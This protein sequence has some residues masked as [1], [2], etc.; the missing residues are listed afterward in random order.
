MHRYL[1]PLIRQDLKEKMV[2]MG[3]PRQVGKTTLAFQLLGNTGE[4]HPGYL[5]WDA[6][7]VKRALL[8]G[9]LPAQ[10]PLLIFD[11][12]HK[13]KHWRNLIKGIY[14]Q[15]KSQRQI[16]VTGSARL[17]FYRRGGD[18][19]QGRYHYYRLHPLTL[20]EISKQPHS[21]DL[22][23]LLKFGG[24]PE[25]FLK[26]EARH[27]K[28][29][30]N[31]RLTRVVQED[32]V[33]LEHVKE[34]SQI[35][36]LLSALPERV[37]SILSINNLKQDLSV[38]YETVDR[39]IQILENLYVCYRI[40]PFGLPH[41]RAAKKEKKLYLWD[42]SQCPE[43]APRF[44]NLVAAHLLKYCHK[45][46]DTEGD[47]MSLTFVRDASKREIDFVVV[48]NEKPQFAVECKTGERDLSANIGY[49]AQ[50]SNIPYFYQ[51]HQGQ[52]DVEVSTYR[53]RILPFVTLAKELVL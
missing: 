31:E 43:P 15:H 46:E 29:W 21:S 10:Q 6:N 12:I 8:K 52:K 2:F 47:K 39:W 53:A 24:F 14:D 37:G 1:E 4:N 51:V 23:H 22:E 27:Y 9:E 5:S 41:L 25:P 20:A 48:K 7:E 36:L 17:D 45:I 38:A 28:R 16:L 30:Q 3:G 19:L 44:E 18:S 26:A 49:Y 32:L 13:Y 40:A 50:R 34:I 35:N 11:E 42:W 33:S